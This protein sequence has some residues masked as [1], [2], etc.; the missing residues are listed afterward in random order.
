M[1]FSDFQ[2]DIVSLFKKNGEV[3]ENIKAGVQPKIIFIQRSDILI[4]TGDLIQ[5]KMSNGGQETYEVIDP[6]FREKS[7][8]SP[9]HYQIRHRNL[10]LPEAKKAIESIVYNLNGPNAKVNNNSVDNSINTVNMNSDIAE[11]ISALRQEIHRLLDGQKQK[12]ALEIA[13]A[14]DAQFNS[15]SPSKLVLSTLI[16]VLPNVASISSIG[17]FLLSCIS[18]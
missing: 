18:K 13:D 10:G 15:N 17:S 7:Q 9:A 11:H 4:E 6:G 5:R 8:I 3:V 12:E 16:K 1:P 2:K 14:I